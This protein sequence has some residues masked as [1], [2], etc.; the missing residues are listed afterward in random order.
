MQ[1][2][3]KV[4]PRYKLR[5]FAEGLGPYQSLLVLA[6][7]ASLAEPLKLA[8]VAIVGAGHW[9]AG[10]VTIVC[11]YAVSLFVVERLFKIVKPKLLMLPWFVRPWNWFVV[12]R[13][14]IL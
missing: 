11:A 8:A 6:V 14:R 10:M 3:P 7:P 4:G 2:R 12:R 1:S 5:R 13:E 9:L